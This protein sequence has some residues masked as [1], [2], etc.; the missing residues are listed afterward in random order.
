MQWKGLGVEEGAGDELHDLE[1]DRRGE[2]QVVLAVVRLHRDPA[3]VCLL[4]EEVDLAVIVGVGAPRT[5]VDGGTVGG[6]LRPGIEKPVP[7][8]SNEEIR[9]LLSSEKEIPNTRLYLHLHTQDKR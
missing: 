5:L 2:Y 9:H 3:P 6:V 7:A 4:I 1:A 8:A